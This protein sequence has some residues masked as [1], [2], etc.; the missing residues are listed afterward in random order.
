MNLTSRR[1]PGLAVLLALLA[2]AACTGMRGRTS[3]TGRADDPNVRGLRGDNGEVFVSDQDLA[4]MDEWIKRRRWI[5]ADDVEIDASKEYFSQYV[6]IAARIGVVHQELTES[7]GVTT[8]TLTY[9][10]RPED[11]DMVSAPRVLVGLGITASARK[12]LVLRLHKTTNPDV[13]VRFRLVA[14]GKASAGVGDQV[15]NRAP[16]LGM[17][18]TLRRGETG[19]VFEEQ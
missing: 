13:P 8:T 1:I 19:Y 6:S 18:A 15:V 4:P 12:R 5:L 14:R 3:R 11:L 10:G 9:T 16:E 2:L 7:G 17:G